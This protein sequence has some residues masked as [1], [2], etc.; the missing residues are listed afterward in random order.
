MSFAPGQL[1]DGA[2]TDCLLPL[3][4][5]MSIP[6]MTLLA[7][8]PAAIDSPTHMAAP[9][10]LLM[11]KAIPRMGTLSNKAA[12]SPKVRYSNCRSVI[13]SSICKS[14]IFFCAKRR[15]CNCLPIVSDRIAAETKRPKKGMKSS[16]S[17]ATRRI[18]IRTS[19][20]AIL[21]YSLCF[22]V[23]LDAFS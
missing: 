13:H 15:V 22:L 11:L 17:R 10:R 19:G 3:L 18:K 21:M 23:F 5:V 8:G 12:A 16:G 14:V 1:L 20:F 9:T 2:L 7:N 6:A 4:E